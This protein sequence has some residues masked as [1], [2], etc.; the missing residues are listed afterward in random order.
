MY[1][2]V[3]SMSQF[4]EVV[5]DYDCVI[6][7]GPLW[8]SDEERIYWTDIRTGR[9]FCYDPA[10]DTH[11]N[12]FN[13]GR[14]GGFTIQKDGTL[15]LFMEQ[16]AIKI[17]DDGELTSVIDR[18][19][20]IRDSRFNDV[21]ADPEGRVFCGT[22]PTDEDLGSLYRLSTS[23]E[24]TMILGSIDISNGLGFTPNLEQLYYTETMANTIYRF[25]YCRET[26]EI[27]DQQVFVDFS[28]RDGIP[29]GLTVDTEGYVWSAIHGAGYVARFGLDGTEDRRLELP[30]DD[31]TSLT[32]GGPN[33]SD[34]YI[35]SAS[36]QAEDDPDAGALFRISLDDIRGREEFRSA[37]NT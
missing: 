17:W 26:G 21:I 28:D 33:Y 6:G 24:L 1:V 29:D 9:M 7:E 31:V 14:V 22:M 4:P 11:E 2:E 3:K 35:T 8:H 10:T 30:T 19:P 37:V 27:S 32:F 13:D 25:E 20:E 23:G 34:M 16:G 15:L 36:L 12:F 5:A 18:V